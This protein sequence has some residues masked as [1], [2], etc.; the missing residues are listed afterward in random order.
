MYPGYNTNSPVTSYHQWLGS[1]TYSC[2]TVLSKV[3]NYSL[4]THTLMPIV[5]SVE[6]FASISKETE[7][8]EFL[9]VYTDSNT[10]TFWSCVYCHVS[11]LSSC[12]SGRKC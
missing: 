12:D 6:V 5:S 7:V 3:I 4:H 1:Q 10:C 11:V 8:S 9:K 2:L